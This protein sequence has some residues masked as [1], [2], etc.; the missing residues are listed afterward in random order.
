MTKE[1]KPVLTLPLKH[2]LKL[3]YNID[4]E[5]YLE[6]D[7]YYFDTSYINI[8]DYNVK[9]FDK[10]YNKMTPIKE[11]NQHTKHEIIQQAMFYRYESSYMSETY[12]KVLEYAVN[13]I[14]NDFK[15]ANE[16]IMYD[17]I[18]MD[19]YMTHSESNEE[20][21]R[22]SIAE[23]ERIIKEN[24]TAEVNTETNEVEFYGSLEK[25]A[26]III[27]TLHGYGMFRFVS[28]QE[29]CEVDE[30]ADYTD[31]ELKQAIIDHL[32]WLRKWNSIYGDGNFTYSED[33]IS[34]RLNYVTLGDY[35][36]TE[37]DIM[38][39]VEHLYH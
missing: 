28:L 31:E 12:N 35:D 36:F 34:N 15:N 21:I 33:D 23:Q 37:D 5:S 10:V 32:H 4:P 19:L 22:K 27:A 24:V 9:H 17:D 7:K 13:E 2:V 30:G 26:Y 38:I 3:V 18:Q 14:E 29:L 8:D 11:V 20:E 1:Q 16:S 39:A 25:L 6:P